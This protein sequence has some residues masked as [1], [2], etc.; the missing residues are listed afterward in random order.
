MKNLILILTVV[1]SSLCSSSA[2]SQGQIK[3]S[4]GLPGDNLNLYAVLDIFQQC[5]TLEEFEGKLNAQ[6][7]KINNLDLNGDNKIDYLKVID[8]GKGNMHAIVIKDEINAHEMQD[9]AVIEVNKDANGKITIQVVGDEQLYGKNYIIEPKDQ[10]VSASPTSTPNPGYKGQTSGTTTINNYYYDDDDYYRNNYYGPE[11]YYYG[12][13]HIVYYP[14]NSWYMW[15][16]LYAPHYVFYVSPWYWGFYPSY[17]NPWVPLYWHEY[18]GYHYHNYGY[19]HRCNDYRSPEIQTY[20]GARR[21]VSKIVTERTVSRSY[22]ST[23]GKRELLNTTIKERQNP[24]NNK[25]DRQN[26]NIK[27]E[28]RNDNRINPAR[29]NGT[30]QR[31]ENGRDQNINNQQ[32]IENRGTETQ[33][34]NDIRL[35]ENKPRNESR[36]QQ[37]TQPRNDNRGTKPGRSTP[38]P[39]RQTAPQHLNRNATPQQAPRSNNGGGGRK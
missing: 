20:Y 24:A 11:G 10:D 33:P 23:Y 9:V 29:E 28:G 26:T 8:N 16:Y 18:Y 13:R 22:T 4:L 21:S 1:G 30:Q 39:P 25:T 36:P 15:D 37:N 35:N 27:T 14:V 34:R 2:Y 32:R 17:W 12:G 19:F 38:K 7:S 6:D 5:K 3:D 31:N